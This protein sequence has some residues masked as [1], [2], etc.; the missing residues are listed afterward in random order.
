MIVALLVC[1]FLVG[2]AQHYVNAPL[3][4]FDRSTGYRP[5]N[6]IRRDDDTLMLVLSFSGG[7]TRAAA[8][9]Y[10]VLEELA[11]TEVYRNGQMRRLVDEID[12]ITSVS[13]GS[14]TAAYFGLFGDRIFE[15]FEE[16][17]LNRDVQG[18]LIARVLLNPYNWFRLASPSFSRSD[19]AAEYYNKH[20]FDGRSFSDMMAA[21]APWIALNATELT[22]GSRYE[23]SQEYFDVICSDLA[24][25]PVAR[26]VAAS[27]AVPVL[28]SAV[29]LRNYAGECGYTMSKW[30]QQTLAQGDRLNALYNSASHIRD[31]Q[32]VAALPNLHLFDGGLSD[33]LGIR[34]V[35]TG[36]QRRG[37]DSIFEQL[38]GKKFDRVIF[39]VVNAA[40]KSPRAAAQRSEPSL[41]QVIGSA[42]SVPLERYSYETVSRLRLQLEQWN[43]R[44]N[45]QCDS[46]VTVD[47]KKSLA[48]SCAGKSFHLINLSFSE[49]SSPEERAYLENLPTSFRLSDGEV[50]RLRSAGSFLLQQ[51]PEYSRL[52]RESERSRRNELIYPAV[53]RNR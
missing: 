33:N 40:T 12:F 34:A 2:C 5:E 36:I 24:S 19:L 11:R 17:F 13:G 48:A 23:F 46:Q 3:E 37:G 18:A 27:S 50:D 49:H 41:A 15:D 7:G 42:S 22:L 28:L 52:M 31:L 26:A 35:L 39:I 29:T 47:Q 6:V 9:A 53:A 20:I 51:N 21:R 10:G 25:F 1:G 38:S 30:V 45:K 16:R 32:N 4:Q 43:E 8:F 44:F 14:F